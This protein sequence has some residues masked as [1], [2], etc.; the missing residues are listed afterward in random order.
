M[1]KSEPKIIGACSHLPF[2]RGEAACLRQTVRD[3]DDKKPYDHDQVETLALRQI[4]GNPILR[5][6]IELPPHD[7]AGVSSAGEFQCWKKACDSKIGI[8]GVY[9]SR[10][11]GGRASC[12][13]F[14]EEKLLRYFEMCPFV[15]EIRTQY[16]SW[17]WST[18][19]RYVQSG[20]RMPTA[21]VMTIDFMLTLQIPGY[22][23]RLY[24][25]V[26]GKPLSL[27]TDDRVIERHDREAQQIWKWGC[28]HEVMTEWTVSGIEHINNRRLLSFMLHTDDLENYVVHAAELARALKATTAKGSLDRVLS[29]VGRRLGWG[30]RV[31]YRIFGIAHFLGYLRWN[32]RF[33]LNRSNSMMLLK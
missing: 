31:A 20:R 3:I 22:P 25:G 4:S 13:S 12:H 10:K 19:Y 28:T 7:P 15:V 17:D 30:Q 9:F 32:H 2:S 11:S 26:S 29:M 24:H 8:A 33:E 1:V 16:P 18:Y 27:L 23:F 21:K 14:L 6:P 5:W